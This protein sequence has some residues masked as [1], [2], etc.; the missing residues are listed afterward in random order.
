MK[1][2]ITASTRSADLTGVNPVVPRD[3][4]WRT[5]PRNSD[6]HAAR[7]FPCVSMVCFIDSKARPKSPVFDARADL[8]DIQPR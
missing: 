1:L 8:S 6:A 7:R 5:G 3:S 4:G 2:T